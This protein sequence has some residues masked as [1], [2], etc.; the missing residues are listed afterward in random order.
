M[1]D[2]LLHNMTVHIHVQKHISIQMNDN[3]I[4]HNQNENYMNSGTESIQLACVMK[5]QQ[6]W[7]PAEDIPH[8]CEG[9]VWTRSGFP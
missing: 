3:S 6:M 8:Y 4:T 5:Y 9:D 2:E 7:D 1:W